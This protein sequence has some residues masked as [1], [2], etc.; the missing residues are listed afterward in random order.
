MQTNDALSKGQ[1]IFSLDINLC[2]KVKQCLQTKA[3]ITS[4]DELSTN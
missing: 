2:L 4:P 3:C 1:V